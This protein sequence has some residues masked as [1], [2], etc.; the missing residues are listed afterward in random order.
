MTMVGGFDVYRKPL[1][2]DCVD[3]NGLVPPDLLDRQFGVGAPNLLL[4]ADFTYV[5]LVTGGSS[6]SHSPSTP[7]PGRSSGGRPR[8]PSTPGSWNRRSA[9][10]PHCDHGRAIRSPTPSTTRMRDLRADST[11]SQ[12]GVVSSSVVGRQ[13]LPPVFSTRVSCGA[14]C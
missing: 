3:D 11:S 14:G 10:P 5:K 9:R 1:T 4:G 2:F 12:H 13:A 6:M 7:T 8:A